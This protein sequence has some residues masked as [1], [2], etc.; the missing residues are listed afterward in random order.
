[1]EHYLGIIGQEW[2]LGSEWPGDKVSRQLVIHTSGLF[3]WAVIA[4]RFIK[5]GQEFAKDRLDEILEGTGFKG[6]PE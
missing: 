4:Y 6:T 1:L 2:T 3:I 5:D